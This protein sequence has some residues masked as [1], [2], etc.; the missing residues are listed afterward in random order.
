MRDATRPLILWF[1]RDLRLDDNPML[2]AA[3]ASGRPL[4]PVFVA[5]SSVTGLG[6]AAR[7]RMGRAVGSFQ[8]RLRE[9]GSGLVLR[10]GEAGPILRAL[11]A[12]TGAVGVWWTRLH[13]PVARARDSAIKASFR[14]EGTDA[15]G[16]DGF[17]L[18]EPW[19]LATREG[20]FFKVYTPF[21]NAL[22]QRGV[23]APVAEPLALRPPSSWPDSEIL[24]NW[25][26]DAAVDRGA[27][28]LARYAQVGEKAA[29]ARLDRFLSGPIETYRD[30]RDYPARDA[31]SGLSE[32][33]TCGEISPR[34]I[35]HAAR[36]LE[37]AV[38]GHPGAV[39]FRKELAWRD[40]AQHLM[41]HTPRIL[42]DNWRADWDGFPWRGDG[43]GEDDAAERWRRGMTGEPLVDA[44][45]RQMHVTGTMH[46]RVRMVVASYLAKHLLTHWKIGLDWF[47]EHLTDWDPASNAMGWQWVAGSGPD[48][49]PYFRV[50]NPAR[51]A[52][53]FDKTKQYRRK[54]IYEINRASKT[55]PEPA[56][57]H[58]SVAFF[59]AVPRAWGLEP[60]RPYP[61]PV[62]DLD[63][64]RQRALAAFAAWRG[65]RTIM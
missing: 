62:V 26:L 40:F 44:G 39:H 46:N 51:Q 22:E 60:G 43:E 64:G 45:L 49:A 25:R 42:S 11:I 12:E 52:E 61:R 50:F 65:A 41:Y 5:D 54:F 59:D 19:N 9:R 15:R 28:V 4:I 58:E 53:K 13:D 1:R 55:D 10:R 36:A 57:D 27:S 21:W 23:A 20:R 8:R 47:S 38:P 24:E 35:W 2:A 31:V 56:P 63:E 32:N 33:L 7:W 18:V 30:D 14:A 6:A 29:L 17:T 16:F 48:A 3:A 34:R 37:A